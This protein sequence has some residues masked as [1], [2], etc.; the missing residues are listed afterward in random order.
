M[1][2]ACLRANVLTCRKH[3]NFLFLH[4]SVPIYVPTSHKVKVRQCFNL[5]CQYARQHVDFATW[6]ANMPKGVPVFLKFFLRN[7]KGNSCTLL[8][9]E[10]LYIILDITIIQICICIVHKNYHTSFLYFMSY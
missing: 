9:Y 2:R 6:L 7:A 10:K 4:A 8:L 5:T 1:C 3:A